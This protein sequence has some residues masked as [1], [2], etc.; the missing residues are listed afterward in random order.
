MTLTLETLRDLVAYDPETG[1]F[2]R[3]TSRTRTDR[4]GTV[5]GTVG[6]HGYVRI[7]LGDQFYLAHRLAWFYVYG[8]MPKGKLDHIDR[9]RQNNKI[10]NLRLA[11]D[12]QNVWN[13][14]ARK[15]NK[16]GFKGVTWNKRNKAWT[17]EI[18]KNYKKTYLGSFKDIEDAR[19]AYIKASVSMHGDYACHEASPCRPGMVS[20]TAQ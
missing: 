9:N 17:A 8:E 20:G 13:A 7:T 15:N 5:T 11:S 2:T 18:W 6:S 1:Q 10:S 4:V 19:K 12:S 16:S 14:P 3:L